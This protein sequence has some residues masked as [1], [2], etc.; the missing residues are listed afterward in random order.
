MTLYHFDQ[1]S[2]QANALSGLC[3]KIRYGLEPDNPMLVRLWLDAEQPKVNA[4]LP[5]SIA[6]YERQF[7][8]LLD[9][10][11]DELIPKHWRR[12]CL[13]HA[14]QPLSSQYVARSLGSVDTQS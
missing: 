9:T 14:Y 12:L 11:M 1:D 2:S 10:I 7:R 13:D 4:T 6:F 3:E 5:E 8:L